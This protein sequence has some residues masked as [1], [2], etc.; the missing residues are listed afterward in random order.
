MLCQVEIEQGL[1]VEAQEAEEGLGIAPVLICRDL[2]MPG[3]GEITGAPARSAAGAAEGD[4][5]GFTLPVE[6]D[7]SAEHGIILKGTMLPRIQ[8]V[9]SV[10]AGSKKWQI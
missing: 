4:E 2:Q 3:R 5:I 9:H 1:L 8:A 6:P 10:R 7:G